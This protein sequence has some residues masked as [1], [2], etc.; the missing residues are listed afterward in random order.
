[1]KA[2]SE[3]FA[4][5]GGDV[6]EVNDSLKEHP[7]AINTNPHGTWMIKLRLVAGQGTTS[8]LDSTEYERLV[9]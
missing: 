5:V 2:V 9:R 4:P 8:L 3:L 1:M 7:E 6:I